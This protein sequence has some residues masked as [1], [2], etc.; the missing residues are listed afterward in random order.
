MCLRILESLQLIFTIT[1]SLM[2]KYSL[3]VIFVTQ[4]TNAR[5]LYRSTRKSSM[6]ISN[7]DA[8]CAVLSLHRRGQLMHTR[9]QHIPR[10]LGAKR[11]TNAQ[12]VPL[13]PVL[14][15]NLQNTPN[16][17][18]LS[19]TFVRNLLQIRRASPFTFFIIQRKVFTNVTNVFSQP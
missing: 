17:I 9:N 1:K 4:F 10:P 19:V 13:K 7:K 18:Y 12:H 6:K 16:S 5:A 3:F 11:P 8:I 14:N 15:L 2:T